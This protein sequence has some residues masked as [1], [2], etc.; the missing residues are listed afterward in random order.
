MTD[1]RIYYLFVIFFISCLICFPSLWAQ[2]AGEGSADAASDPGDV[3]NDSESSTNE[4]NNKN[5]DAD[6]QEGSPKIEAPKIA[7][8]PGF[9]ITTTPII[10]SK[11]LNYKV[12]NRFAHRPDAFT[13]GLIVDG[14]IL[15]ESTGRYGKS[16][17]SKINLKSGELIIEEE[18]FPHLFGEGVTRLADSLYQLTFRAGLLLIYDAETLE[19]K[20]EHR[21]N[22]EGWGLTTDGVLLIMSD[23]SDVLRFRKPEDFEE[24]RKV[25]VTEDGSPLKY[26]NELEWVDGK[27]YANVW[28]QNKIVVIDPETGVVHHHIDL[29]ALLKE[30]RSKAKTGVLNGIAYDSETK[31]LYVTGKNWPTLFEIKIES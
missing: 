25:S 5:Q 11:L 3:V 9:T 8:P 29:G 20:S 17:L 7:A 15:I 22:G 30:V 26:L 10:D 24:V 31:R 23:G 4:A 18:L 1:Y 27:I 19:L 21:Y 16:T 6:N 28:L 2:D 12:V 14:D 13:Q